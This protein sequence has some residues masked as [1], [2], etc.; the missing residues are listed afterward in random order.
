[1]DDASPPKWHLAHVT[2]FFETFLLKKQLSDY[3]VYHPAFEVLFNSYYNG[4]GE[5][6]PR[7]RRGHLSRP[8]VE[9]VLAYRQHV[10][11]NMKMLLERPLSEEVRFAI[12]LG[13]HHEQQHQEL[14]ITD[15]KYNLGNNPLKPVYGGLLSESF[16]G[17]PAGMIGFDGGLI[18]IGNDGNCG[19]CFDNETPRHKVYVAPFQLADRLVTNGEFIEFIEDGGYQRPE[20]WLSDGWSHLA[21]LGDDRWSMP[22]YW[23]QDQGYQVYRLSGEALVDPAEPVCHVS[24][25]EADAYARWKGLRLPT[26]AEWEYA[27]G[28]P[29]A[30]GN[31]V[32]SGYFHPVSLDH[33]LSSSPIKQAYGDVWEWTASSYGPYPGFQLFPGQLGEYNGKFMSNQLVLRGG[34]CATSASHIRST[35]RNFFY[36]PDRWQFS[37]I[38]LA[39]D[40]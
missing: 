6:F 17:E 1:M 30:A 33:T 21:S 8:D 4:V 3:Q 23:R 11:N 5:Q 26:E 10:D 19:F 2:W 39:G 13:L 27:V 16:T 15:L 38:R 37:G 28:E 22:L 12:E 24:F 20:L 36:P 9:E 31:F 35:Y 18:E 34:S 7:P 14:L 32:D 40:I 25:Y 29:G